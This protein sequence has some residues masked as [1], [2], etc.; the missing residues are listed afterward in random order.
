MSSRTG[1]RTGPAERCSSDSNCGTASTTSATIAGPAP[2]GAGRASDQASKSATQPRS[3]AVSSRSQARS[4]QPG[5]ARPPCSSM[6]PASRARSQSARTCRAV[7]PQRLGG[8]LHVGRGQ[9]SVRPGPQ[10]RAGAAG[11][12]G[13]AGEAGRAGQYGAGLPGQL[14]RRRGALGRAR[15]R[16]GGPGAHR[17]AG[18]RNRLAGDESEP[19]VAR[20]TGRHRS[21]LAADGPKAQS[22]PGWR[23]A[24]AAP[25][26]RPIP[27]VGSCPPV[28]PGVTRYRVTPGRTGPEE[29]VA[30]PSS[31]R[32]ISGVRKRRRAS[33]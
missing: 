25:P 6:S 29:P 12:V 20:G 9:R 23:S 30:E 24:H 13:P 3:A 14:R 32:Y 16:A 22:E 5:R 17:P 27:D 15:R 11:A 26:R 28:R 18:G 31:C 7:E 33:S 19:G 2:A 8:A 4:R 21:S 1:S 10:S